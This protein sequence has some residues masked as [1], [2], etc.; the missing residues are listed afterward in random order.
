MQ[1]VNEAGERQRCSGT[2]KSR[3]RLGDLADGGVL[4]EL[5]RSDDAQG[6][7]EAGADLDTLKMPEFP[8]S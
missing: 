8:E 7:E 4:G 3:R 1:R 5:E 6:L 2:G